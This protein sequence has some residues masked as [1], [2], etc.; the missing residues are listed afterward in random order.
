MSLQL[1]SPQY[2]PL[3]R[4]QQHDVLAKLG[5]SALLGN[6]FVFLKENALADQGQSA[7]PQ[8]LFRGKNTLTLPGV[9]IQPT[10]LPPCT[11]ISLTSDK[12]L[13]RAN[14]DVIRLLVASPTEANKEVV[15]NISLNNTVYAKYP[16]MLDEFGLCLY[17]LRD[18]PE[19]QYEATLVN[20][21]A[22]ACRFEV[23]EYRLAALHAEL[24]A[25]ELHGEVLRYTLSVTAFNQP[26]N[27]PA[28]VEL[29]E[30]GQRVGTRVNVQCDHEGHYHGTVTL[31]G[32]GPYTLNI[33]V[34]ERTATVALKGSEQERRETLTMSELGELRVLS[35]LPLPQ[36]NAC[37]GMY[38][39]RGGAN[40]EPFLVRNVIGNAIEITPRADVEALRVV[41]INP[42]RGTSGEKYYEQLKPD[43]SIQVPVPPPY[44]IVLLGAFI[45]GQA[46][47]GWCAVLRPS[48]LQLQCIAPEEAKPGSRVKVILKTGMTDRVVPVQ[49]IVKD[50]RLIAQS[51]TQV[52]FAARIKANIGEWGLR[53]VTG[54]IERQLSQVNAMPRV[55]RRMMMNTATMTDIMP[56]MATPPS[57]AGG[58]QILSSTMRAPTGDLA[59]PIAPPVLPTQLTN[60]RLSFPEVIHNSI[61]R[62]QGEAIVEV[63]L[64]DGMTRYTVE[65]FALSPQ[66][67]D[68]QRV[69]TTLEATQEVYG[70]LTVSPFVFPGDSVM[71][72]LDIG[73]TSGKALVEVQH[74]GKVLPLFS[75][76]GDPIQAGMPIL[77]GTS[78]HF[79][80][81][82]GTI[83]SIV[84]DVRSGTSDVS[85][86][87]VTEPGKLR[88]IVRT[89][90]LLTPGKAVTLQDAN[91]LELRPMP[92]L[93]RPFQVF[94]EA[95]SLY[96][97][98]CVEQTSTKLFA[99]YVGYI[100]NKH[101]EQRAS[102]YEAA[103]IIWHKRL[104]SMYLP[105]KGFCLYPPA[106]GAKGKPDTHYA[107]LAVKRLL[108]LPTAEQAVE[109]SSALHTLLNDIRTMAI[110][111]AGYY[112]IE[113]PLRTIN[114]CHDAYR[115]LNATA[116]PPGKKDEAIA[117][118][119]S[120][121]KERDGVVTVAIPEQNPLFVLFG[122]GIAERQETAY[123]AAVL[124]KTG[125][126]SDLSLA[127]AATNTIASQI[128]AEGRLYST[129][130]SAACLA[131][132]IALR[133]AGV[134]ADDG[135]GRVAINGQ[136][137]ALADAL[138]YRE[139]VL[140][141]QCVQG[142]V[143]AQITS[144]VVEDWNTFKRQLAVEVRLE[145]KGHIQEQ[146]SV[147]DE[148]DLVI[149]VRQ[150]EPG[151]LAHVCLP[152][153]LARIVGG[154]QVKRFS[155]DFCGKSELSI[156]LAALGSTQSVLDN[157]KSSQ[158]WAVIV[159]NMFKEEQVGNPGLLEVVVK[160]NN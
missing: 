133:D 76:T 70:E 86:R 130:D 153:A 55:F 65:A 35:L 64:G 20:S 53:S 112:K 93:E 129:V 37:R 140:S 148:L 78:V 85:E 126:T 40:T 46:W 98:G 101:N 159:R 105:H 155:L 116:L 31:T 71:G 29:Q 89:L 72:R 137:M 100:T 56:M 145:R 149:T 104:V 95:A 151:L 152:D 45:D 160:T 92:G 103:L 5:E 135:N 69:E 142:A 23:A 3:V 156:P 114:T 48:D 119:R 62:V 61:V 10:P 6:W 113:S 32:V 117:F 82:P 136:E 73:V 91:A 33:F 60:V 147:S 17:T 12:T 77:S 108:D 19:G 16:L 68:W 57:P 38:V 34:G 43:Q 118:V 96:P 1:P 127:I 115:V 111:A 9:E 25:Q 144:E 131:L 74:D 75:D 66:T 39:A 51:D 26:Y 42:V 13:Y 24:V 122:S 21:P 125:E 121:L 28:E 58:P 44:G 22:D 59:M 79:P 63:K 150:Y 67:L 8:I 139:K 15:L 123:A 157:K 7:S 52:E 138:S 154:G 18:L 158:H 47:E 87:Y 97:Y 11:L 84:R 132:M 141:L 14:R 110:D 102:E 4:I 120:R 128:N 146:F 30:R 106:D 80:V 36:A 54:T 143:A 107:P 27:G 83:T 124:L 99:M 90:R 94:V 109:A 49:L 81:G 88:H 41:I 50:A 2:D 134:V